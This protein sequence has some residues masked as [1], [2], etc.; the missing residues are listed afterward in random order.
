MVYDVFL[1]CAAGIANLYEC[2][3]PPIRLPGVSDERANRLYTSRAA[4]ADKTAPRL[5]KLAT[6]R[7][8]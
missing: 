1:G 3:L 4:D 6:R 2:D 8:S 7:P 5:A